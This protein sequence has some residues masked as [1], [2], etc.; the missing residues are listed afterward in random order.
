LGTKKP[1][2]GKATFIVPFQHGKNTILATSGKITDFM[3]IQF[4]MVPIHTRNLDKNSFEIAI[5]CGSNAF[6]EDPKS[7]IIWGPDKEYTP[8]GW[9]FVKGE[10]YRNDP[11][12]IGHQTSIGGTY[13][14]PLYQTFRMGMGSYKF[15]LPMGVYEVEL[16]FADI[17]LNKEH[18]LYDM[19]DIKERKTVTRE[20]NVLVNGKMILPCFNPARVAGSFHAITKR[21]TIEVLGDE[22]LAIDFVDLVG[23]QAVISGIKI[24]KF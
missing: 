15:D 11:N 10:P 8:G 14:D 4:E 3:E 1:V 12:R 19:A 17:D 6:Y 9:G 2:A 23:N 5:N 24:R 20:F 22:G 21:I 7:R 16:H 18:V 13:N